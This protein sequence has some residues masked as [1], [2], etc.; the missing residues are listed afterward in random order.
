MGLA[1]GPTVLITGANSGIGFETSRELAR[2]SARVL[3]VARDRERGERALS[4][5]TGVAERSAAPS[6]ELLIADL[7][8]PEQVQFLIDTIRARHS[9]ISVLVN[10]AGGYFAHRA[11]TEEGFERTWALNVV[12]PIRL[13]LGL[14][15]LL[16]ESAP[17]R[18]IN[19]ASHA[20]TAGRLDMDDLQMANGTY[21]GFL[22]YARAKSALILWTDAL[23]RRTNP[24]S[25]SAVSV[26]PGWINTGFG[27]ANRGSA[28]AAMFRFFT[29]LFAAPAAKGARPIVELV[30]RPPV[31]DPPGDVVTGEYFLKTRRQ[32][33]AAHARDR[34]VADLLWELGLTYKL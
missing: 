28:A 18:V 16:T 3:M 10:N 9:R 27:A 34:R 5:V 12:A 20:H 21:R 15:D 26:H 30:D 33:P 22:Q 29:T 14:L 32:L 11:T 7:T 1:D 24:Q 4:D 23:A 13:T 2:R 31:G 6:P 25:V 8:D 19:V 17:A